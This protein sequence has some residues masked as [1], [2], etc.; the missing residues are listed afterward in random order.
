MDI[1]VK[2]SNLELKLGVQIIEQKT[3]GNRYEPKIVLDD[4]VYLETYGNHQPRNVVMDKNLAKIK[5]QE[6]STARWTL[7]EDQLLMKFNLGTNVK[8]QLVKIQCIAR[9]KK[10]WKW[11]NC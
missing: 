2:T 9:N 5:A 6:L 4:K 3:T 11:N 7:T 8:P 1:N 10:C